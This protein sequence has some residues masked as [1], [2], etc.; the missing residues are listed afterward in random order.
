MNHRKERKTK[1]ISS[2]HLVVLLRQYYAIE[3]PSYWL[4]AGQ[5]GGQYSTSSVRAVFMKS[6]KREPFKSMVYSTHTTTF[7]CYALHRK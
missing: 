3:K 4:F 6:S 7:L 1:T 2:K 5:T